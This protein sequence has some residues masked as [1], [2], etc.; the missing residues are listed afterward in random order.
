[1]ISLNWTFSISAPELFLTVTTRRLSRCLKTIETALALGRTF[2]L[3]AETKSEAEVPLD[4]SAWTVNR[5][6][7]ASVLLYG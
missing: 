6:G 5:V 2:S 7:R 1:M 3:T 4:W